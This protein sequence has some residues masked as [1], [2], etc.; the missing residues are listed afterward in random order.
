MSYIKTN[1]TLIFL[2]LVSLILV[3]LFSTCSPLYPIN[4]W[5]DA[6]VFMSIGKSLLS[7]KL[8]YTD[9]HDHKG[10]LLFF[11]HEWAAAVSS[12]SFMG[13]YLLEI[14]CSFGFLAFS[15][16]TMRLFAVHGISLITTCVVGV[17]TYTSDFM[18]YGDTV[19]EFSLPI[20]LLVLYK[21]LQYAKQD[22][23]PTA[24]ESF[25]IGVGVAAIFWM[26]FTILLMCV[27]ALASLLIMASQ[28]RQMSFL[29][30]CLFWCA[31]GAVGLTVGV[32][33]Y[34]ILH[35]NGA[36]LYQSYF[37]LNIFHYAGRGADASAAWWPAK[38]AGWL[39]LVGFVLTRR[40]SRDV[41]I[42]V[43]FCWG[44]E[45]LTFVLFKVFLYYFLPIFVF[46][47]LLIY[48]V[49]DIR[50]KTILYTGV[51]A[52]TLSSI[53][54]NYNLMTFL[55]GNFPQAVLS[56]AKT[57]NT[58]KDIRK[59]VLT[60]RSYDTGIYTLTDCLPPIKYFSTPD[61]YIEELVREQTDYM[62][63]CQAKYII[64]KDDG[65]AYYYGSF[66]PNIEQDYILIQE[67]SDKY[68]YEFLLHPLQFLWSLGYMN[69]LIEKI[70]TPKHHNVNYR[71]Y[72]LKNKKKCVSLLDK[73]FD[74]CLTLRR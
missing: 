63:S 48:F 42:T 71:L 25:F 13:I 8:L 56:L 17:L 6:N 46:A 28:R 5:E 47:P 40:M 65:N 44:A 27:G 69:R 45:L 59:K 74:P 31:V 43:A 26:K 1:S 55:T 18:L 10:P 50:S 36:N 70:Y 64:Q 19:E 38:L 2:F 9:V 30:L 62:E 73:R 3:T 35:G 57:V 49:R 4:P 12:K 24:L 41:K 54:T 11:L 20:L 60:V 37:Y 67:A 16:K 23:L 51:L 39:L 7:G 21:T 72:R 29:M 53:A 58:D 15:Y 34:F 32:L 68:R 61:V 22:K 14:L 33:L 66:R 52:L